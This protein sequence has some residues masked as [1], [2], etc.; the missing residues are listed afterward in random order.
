MTK[1]EMITKISTDA[2]ITKAK[3][4]TIFDIIIN[5][6]V[7]GLKKDGRVP[8]FGLGVFEVVKRSKRKGR[9]PRTGEPLVVKAHKAV[10]F[11]PSKNVKESVNSS[12]K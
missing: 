4:Q 12:A 2:E 11:K 7:N 3:A 1:S 8:L 9:N 10:K 6:V 5:I